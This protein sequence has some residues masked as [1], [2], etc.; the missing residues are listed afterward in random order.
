M[1]FGVSARLFKKSRGIYKMSY[2]VLVVDDS[3]FVRM[4]IRQFLVHLGYT[5]ILEAK[6]GFEA[7][8]FYKEN[9]P[10][11][12]ILDVTMPELDGLSALK[13]IISFDPTAKVIMCSA[14]SQELVVREALALGAIDFVP[15]PFRLDEL[16]KI[17][18]Q[19]L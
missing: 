1:L 18:M 3:S 12:T 8:E 5:N 19:Y 16:G 13:E 6:N 2:K 17:I 15:K 7:V 11:L 14:I 9:K 10:A 4:M